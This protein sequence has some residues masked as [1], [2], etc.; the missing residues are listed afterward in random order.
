MD[1]TLVNQVI[2]HKKPLLFRTFSWIRSMA[3][4]SPLV[5]PVMSFA[6]GDRHSTN[7]LTRLPAQGMKTI[8]TLLFTMRTGLFPQFR[9]QLR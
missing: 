1:Q 7:R 9:Q 8:S 6:P 4:V 3:E 2:A 5:D